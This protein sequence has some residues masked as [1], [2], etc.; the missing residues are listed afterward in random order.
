MRSTCEV[1]D[2]TDVARRSR[3][4]R[5]GHVKRRKKGDH[6][7]RRATGVDVG[8]RLKGRLMQTQ[9]RRHVEE[10]TIKMRKRKEYQ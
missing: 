9:L 1:M 10:S 6:V 2:V 7:H 8:V 4:R 5:Y 3:L